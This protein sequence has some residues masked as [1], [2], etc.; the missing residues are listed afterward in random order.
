MAEALGVAASV[1]QIV[2]AVDK[3]KKLWTSVQNAPDDLIDCVEDIQ[4]TTR[5]LKKSQELVVSTTGISDD[6]LTECNQD[7]EHAL[8]ALR[9]VTSELQ[10]GLHQNKR[11]GAFNIVLKKDEIA[12][13]RRK[14]E[15][16]QSL[17]S[18]AQQNLAL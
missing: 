6:N 8:T 10:K 16:T 11:I 5:L 18:A 14:L 7:L 13:G 2:D 9:G 12:K 17:L 4:R 1:I 3:V 15:R